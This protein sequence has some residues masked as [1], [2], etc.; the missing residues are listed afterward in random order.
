LDYGTFK[1]AGQAEC[2]A[3]LSVLSGAWR[4]NQKL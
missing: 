2:L 3:V 1:L 4:G